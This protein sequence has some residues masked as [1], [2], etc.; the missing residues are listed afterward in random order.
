VGPWARVFA[1][2]HV[3]QP[4]HG[5]V[6]DLRVE[7]SLV[8]ARVDG[9]RV[10]LSAPPIAGGIWAAIEAQVTPDRQS[11]Q[12]AQLLEH[13]WEEPL[14][15]AELVRVGA[16][17]D[18]AAVAHAV[19][20]EIDRDPSTLLRFRGYDAGAAAGGNDAWR[21]G[22]LP[23]LPPPARRPPDSVPMRL[24]TSGIRTADGDLVDVLVRVYS[25]F[26]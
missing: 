20:E 9:R 23:P 26:S 25:A 24:G 15:P 3:R 2:L 13:T 12:L 8:T 4:S 11:E 1:T 6:T 7:P 5:T 17:E 21:G 19:A 10:S 18:V 22:E 16:E 14:V